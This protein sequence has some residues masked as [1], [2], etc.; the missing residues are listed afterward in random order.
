MMKLVSSHSF[1]TCTL[2]SHY[3]PDG[4]IRCALRMKHDHIICNAV[5]TEGA[6]SQAVQ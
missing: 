6:G 4:A 3:V 2:R 5:A 1:T